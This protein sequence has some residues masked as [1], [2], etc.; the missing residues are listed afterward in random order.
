MH[1]TCMYQD[2]G[3]RIIDM[4]IIHTCIRVKDRGKLINASYMH[5]QDQGSWIVHLTYVCHMYQDQEYIHHTYIYQGQGSYIHACFR[6]RVQ[7]Q[8]YVHHSHMH[9]SQGSRN[10]DKC[11]HH[12][13]MSVG[14]KI[15]RIIDTCT[16]HT[17]ML[18]DQGPGS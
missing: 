2:Q 4:C 1:H 12:T 14:D 7:D 8:R 3:S 10:I 17:C 6:I 16:I 5:Y 18:Q 13:R 15:C 9:Q 11:M